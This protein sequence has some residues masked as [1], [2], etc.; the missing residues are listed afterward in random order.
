MNIKGLLKYVE[1]STKITS[2]FSFAL[3]LSFLFYIG[4]PINYLLTGIFF[5]GM[6]L[7]D[8]ATTAIN[9][10]I[11]SKTNDQQ[12][13]FGR[14][15]A[16]AIIYALLSLSAIA[17]I[18]LVALTDIIVLIVGG[19][20]FAAGVLYTYGPIPISRQPWGE[21]FSG[22]FYGFFIPMLILYINMP[23]DYFFSLDFSLKTVTFSVQLMPFI[24][25]ILISVNPVLCT[26][27]IML[28]NNICDLEKDIKVKRYT[29]PYYLGE[30]ALLLFKWLYY[31]TYFSTVL[32]IL[33]GILHPICILTLLTIIPVRKN[34][35]IFYKKQ[36]KS[37]T[38]LT[39]IKN[40]LLIMGALTL[41]IFISGF[42]G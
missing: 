2:I 34:I 1:I 8:L 6:F 10:Y 20:C 25:L 14:G 4:Q 39:S 5:V 31:L 42:V 28:A 22:V 30:K 9:N 13:P 29:L 11:D 19:I 17:G 26:A 24:M 38:F 32:M 35:K 40:Y 23:E 27:N 18:T 16:L 36:E 41:T 33:M 12:L 37:S 21:V 7:L 3:S 15:K